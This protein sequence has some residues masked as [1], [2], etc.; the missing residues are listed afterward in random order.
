MKEVARSALA[1][2]RM[3][4]STQHVQSFVV[5]SHTLTCSVSFGKS[6][7]VLIVSCDS[8]QHV[9]LSQAA[10]SSACGLPSPSYLSIPYQRPRTCYLSHST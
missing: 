1:G 10:K 8:R 6:S 5:E 3:D 4:R 2:D 9:Y 7:D